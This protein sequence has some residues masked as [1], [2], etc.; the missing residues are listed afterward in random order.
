MPCPALAQIRPLS[1]GFASQSASFAPTSSKRKPRRSGVCVQST[2]DPIVEPA[3]P[4]ATNRSRMA[5]EGL[6]V[7]EDEAILE[8][9]EPREI[10]IARDGAGRPVEARLRR[11]RESISDTWNGAVGK[12]RLKNAPQLSDRRNTPPLTDLIVGVSKGTPL[13]A[14]QGELAWEWCV[15]A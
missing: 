7:A 1:N 10:G 4:A 11:P 5:A 8:V 14:P 9:D 2:N 6:A 13:D 12:R 3:S 15:P